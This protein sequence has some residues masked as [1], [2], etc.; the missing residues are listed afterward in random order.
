MAASVSSTLSA[1]RLL[2]LLHTA[3]AASG[4]AAS[5]NVC[6]SQQVLLDVRLE[7]HHQLAQPAGVQQRGMDACIRTS[8]SR[9]HGRS[10]AS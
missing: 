6:S 10:R 8:V 7:L 4:S 2:L 5:N 3:A 9:W 1:A